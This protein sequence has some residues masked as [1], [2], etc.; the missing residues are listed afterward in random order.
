MNFPADLKYSEEHEWIRVGDDDTAYI[1]ITDH[2]QSELGELVY[3]EVDTLGDEVAKDDIFGTVEAVKTTSDLY[4]PV[5]GTVLEFNPKIDEAEDD[6]PGLINSDP[7]GD[8][9]II[10]VKLSDP[11][12]L[13]SLM[14]SE[15][16]QA[17]LA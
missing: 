9:W 11:S 2:A 5:S 6:E 3:V 8:G 12:E 4:M 14:D 13:D 10:K 17:L 1:G 7:Y 16:Y 15:A